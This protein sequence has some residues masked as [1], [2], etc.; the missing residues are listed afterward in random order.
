MRIVMNPTVQTPDSNDQMPDTATAQEK[1]SEP[2]GIKEPMVVAAIQMVSAAT[3]DA[4]LAVARHLIEEAVNQHGAKLLLLPEYFCFM[5]KRDGDKLTIAEAPG[6]GP[7]QDFLAHMAATHKIWLLGGTL[8][9]QSE[10]VDRI[11]NTMLV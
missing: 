4:N 1:R 9:L 6:S 2:L 3:V 5:G 10:D 8:P 11:Y 7:I